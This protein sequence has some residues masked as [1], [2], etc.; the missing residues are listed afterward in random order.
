M[1]FLKTGSAGNIYCYYG[2]LLVLACKQWMCLVFKVQTKNL[3][4]N[5]PHRWGNEA[6]K[7]LKPTN[8]L[9]FGG[10][11]WDLLHSIRKSFTKFCELKWW[12]WNENSI[13]EQGR[14]IFQSAFH[15]DIG[16]N[17]RKWVQHFY[18]GNFGAAEHEFCDGEALQGTWCLGLTS[19]TG[20]L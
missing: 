15:S 10:S 6:V 8:L 2:F 13:I 3:L 20:I 19:S 5:Y 4:V 1:T 9:Q 14:C 16:N 11:L 17:W 12:C 18:S 7:S